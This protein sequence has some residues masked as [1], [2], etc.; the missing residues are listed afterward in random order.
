MSTFADQLKGL[1]LKPGS[2]KKNQAVHD[3]RESGPR[4]PSSRSGSRFLEL[5]QFATVITSEEG[6]GFGVARD[7]SS[8]EVF[9]HFRA[10]AIRKDEG[11]RIPAVGETIVFVLGSDPRRSDGR[12]ATLWLPVDELRWRTPVTVADQTGLDQA[13]RLE[14]EQVADAALLD[15]VKSTWYSRRWRGEAPSDLEDPLLEEE[16]HRRLSAASPGELVRIRA[17]QALQESRYKFAQLI[18]PQSDSCT[19]MRIKEFLSP[20]QAAAL[21]APEAQW[22][23]A[24]RSKPLRAF[25][26]EWYLLSRTSHPPRGKWQSYFKGTEEYEVELA[27]RLFSGD[28]EPDNF[29]E[30]WLARIA[31]NTQ[32]PAEQANEWA[33]RWP[34]LYGALFERLSP[35]RQ[36]IVVSGWRADPGSLDTAVSGDT[37]RFE[38]MLTASALAFDLETDGESIWEVG[39]AQ[40]GSGE[41]LY[42]R[43]AGSSLD[44]GLSD[45]QKRLRCAPVVVGHNIVEWDWPLLVSRIGLEGASPLLWDTLLV[46]YLLE[47]QASSHALG[48]SH[49]ADQDAMAALEL[50][51]RQ[52]SQLPAGIAR[53]V[54]LGEI[55]NTSDLIDEIAG[56]FEGRAD[57]ARE[58]PAILS[59]SPDPMGATLLVP[60]AL[61][62]EFDWIPRLSVVSADTATGL[63]SSWCRVDPAE[64]AAR[65]DSSA[66]ATRVLTAVARLAA[67][68]GIHLRR[69][70]IPVWLLETDPALIA[71]VDASTHAPAAQE[72]WQRVGALPSRADWWSEFDPGRYFMAGVNTPALVV[73]RRQC[74]WID[75]LGSSG[76]TPA[77]PLS[78]L[79][80]EKLPTWA[81]R[82][83]PAEILSTAKGVSTFKVVSLPDKSLAQEAVSPPEHPPILT[84]HKNLVL[85]PHARDQAAYWTEVLRSFREVSSKGDSAV[86]MLLIGSSTSNQLVEM[87]EIALAE[88]SMA[89]SRPDHRSQREHLRRAAERGHVLVDVVDRWPAWQEHARSLGIPLR[90]FV[91]AI[92]L[93]EW[94]AC[95][96]AE[97]A[98]AKDEPAERKEV[99]GRRA[100][101][102]EPAAVLAKVRE[103][104]E[105]HLYHW[106]GG[107][108]ADLPA[109]ILD[110]RLSVAEVRSTRLFEELELSGESLPKEMIERL[111]PV[112]APLQIQR[113]KAPSGLD[114]MERFLVANWQPKE[115]GGNRVLGFKRSQR[116]AMTVISERASNVL[117]GLPT[118]EG[119]SVLFQVPALCRGLR[120]RRLTLV[121]SPLKALMQDQVKRL[122]DQGFDESADYLSGD[123][124][125][126]EIQEVLQGVLDHRIVLLYVAPERLRSPMFL[127]VL[128]KR[129]HADD[130]LEHVAVDE[131][132]CVNQW[133]YEFRPDYFN[134]LQ[135][136]LAKCKAHDSSQPTQFL[137]LSATLTSS[138][139]EQLGQILSGTD[140]HPGSP[141][142]LVA[143]PDGFFNPLRSHIAVES[144]RVRGFLRDRREFEK[145]L[146]ERMPYI[147]EAIRAARNNRKKTGQRSAVI[148]FVTTRDHAERVAGTI[149]RECGGEVDYYH[150]GLDSET[151]KE[152]YKDFREGRL[153]VLVATKA[154]GMGMDIPDI[155]WVIHLSPPGFLD[156][157]LQEV[158]RVG[159]GEEERRKA[160][161][162]QLSAILLYSNRDFESVRTLRA[163]NALTLPVIKD[164]YQQIGQ[165]SNDLG[166]Q[167]IAVVPAAGYPTPQNPPPQTAAGERSAQTRVRMAIYWLE[168][169]GRL[170]LGSS[171]PDLMPVT[172]DL[173]RLTS[174]SKESGIVGEIAGSILKLTASELGDDE[175]AESTV[176]GLASPNRSSFSTDDPAGGLLGGVGRLLEGLLDA[177]GIVL[178]KRPVPSFLE[179]RL[180]LPSP[181]D[182]R[183]GKSAGSVDMILNLAQIR[184]QGR[185]IESI[186]DV[187]TALGDL[188]SRRAVVFHREVYISHRALGNDDPTLIHKLFEMVD[189][190][191][192][193]LI[194]Q[195]AGRPKVEFNPFELAQDVEGPAVGPERRVAYER[196]FLNGFR[197]LARASGI[198]LRQQVQM[199]EKIIWE[200]ML[201]EKSR[202]NVDDRRRRTRATAESLFTHAREKSAIPFQE[203]IE[204][205]KRHH[206]TKRF[207]NTEFR[208]AARLLAALR[209]M[210]IS[211]DLVPMSHVVTMLDVPGPLEQHGEVWSDLQEI[212]NFAEARHV[213]MEVFASI[214]PRAHAGFIQGY[215]GIS[216]AMS[217][218]GF[219]DTQLGEVV[220]D[221]GDNAASDKIRQMQEVVRATRAGTF[222]EEFKSSEEPAQ[223]DVVRHPFEGHLLV[224]A[225]P[226][227]GKTKVL[228]GRIAH[229]IREQNIDP[230][231]IVV[232]AFNRAVVSEIRMRIRDLFQTLGYAAYAR[233]LRVSTFHTLAYVSL[234]RDGVDLKG[235][236]TGDVM[237]DFARRM[238]S[239]NRFA[240]TV[241]R[242]VRC[243]L[244]DEFQDVTDDIYSVIRGMYRGSGERAG[245]MVIGDDDQDI[246]RWNRPGGQ[247]SERYFE[248]FE[249]H[250]GAK[251]LTKTLLGV[252]F[253]SCTQV[254]ELSQRMISG[255]FD[256]S[257][258]S[259]RMK[260]SLLKPRSEAIPG[261]CEAIEWRRCSWED[262]LSKA[263]LIVK[264]ME[265]EGG[266]IAILC[267]SNA[268]VAEV[269]R[270]LEPVIAGLAI[271]GAVNLR[272]AELRHV[273]SWLDVLREVVVT[274]NDPALGEELKDELDQEWARR[275]QVPELASQPPGAVKVDRLWRLCEAEQPFP[276]VSSL[277]R[278]VEEL[279]S[280]EYFRLL[281]SKTGPAQADLATEEAEQLSSSASEIRVVSTLHKV[282]GLEFDHVVI[283]PSIAEFPFATRSDKGPEAIELAAAEEARMLYVGMTRAERRL[284]YFRGDREVSWGQKVPQEFTGSRGDG[285]LLEGSGKEVYLD[286]ALMEQTGGLGTEGLQGY[287]EHH[288]AVGDPIFVGRNR[289]GERRLLLHR[290]PSDQMQPVGQLARGCGEGSEDASLKVS[291]VVRFYAREEILGRVVKRVREQGWGYVV[292]VAGRLR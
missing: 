39:C 250:F 97:E 113:E 20:A 261:K 280:D 203:L 142:P 176:S 242:D 268:E 159:R 68:Q 124:S 287:I 206:P 89:E 281:A 267:R 153:D 86:P 127:D 215:F 42:D 90:P 119:K 143:A 285:K 107:L 187:L 232:L 200:A 104:T 129:M 111:S 213:A 197:A 95:S 23:A 92:P 185:G 237:A 11:E 34:F 151:R 66:P 227:A 3:R 100:T 8:Q 110:S 247:F 19:P 30:S 182:N 56:A 80:S 275:A 214:D 164:L 177:V 221:A 91:E 133:G 43:N 40:A 264:E 179:S 108:G 48:G 279:R 84:V 69:N 186:G 61:L 272:I 26:M 245:V 224:N 271:E 283:L 194:R 154:F 243:I 101:P 282:K 54:L 166:G 17:G 33:D 6:R 94:Y 259:K 1:G 172:V 99:G 65:V 125:L 273:A 189:G 191:V 238:R 75:L 60:Q 149:A 253:R 210:G 147:Q 180:A 255:F 114:A 57:Y 277:V 146:A 207:R 130:G 128:E 141:M 96:V 168:R 77:T 256:R 4:K 15:L 236:E 5:A 28:V 135:L 183:G 289:Y 257:E 167:R 234:A 161:L 173:Q 228:V 115:E 85:H 205:V 246:L 117:V 102:V 163:R 45:L 31:R 46:Q 51:E 222:F 266:S 216:D 244:V 230:S 284:A 174:I 52:L 204:W 121:V 157:Y 184:V 144:T 276:H 254:V 105:L 73:G 148:V 192:A 235:Q 231:Q 126:A 269:H 25:L 88:M 49:R 162:E 263:A 116:E 62:R 24:T 249:S 14:L 103:L 208:R 47:P 170:Q 29:V 140:K 260:T 225:G 37:G 171:I 211:S 93:E 181:G 201:P 118:G 27:A 38:R 98:A 81:V 137:L 209:L 252:N 67:E 9:F 36:S 220:V 152:V 169:A 223:W 202:Q 123:R 265:Q 196:A 120:N 136:L 226:G 18:S 233:R 190:A 175:I 131:A 82:D 291:A 13:R 145:A 292:L 218:K 35:E 50:F 270:R 76:R 122:W 195:A 229:L 72:E 59:T 70:M 240:E 7:D 199:D 138:D 278:F 53:R 134:A 132:H 248:R 83:G 64:L 10:R 160:G 63:D 78:R 150:A 258:S 158:G 262:A 22:A 58:R 241:A 290:S 79:E 16:L 165:N 198:R 193:E 219:L 155:H 178:G 41:L 21:G 109:V 139:R 288:V 74:A 251:G 212:N 286:W 106:L 12:T 217:L 87:L 188:G 44:D 112:L 274:R 71:A 55:S 2:S 239:D 156:D 32:L